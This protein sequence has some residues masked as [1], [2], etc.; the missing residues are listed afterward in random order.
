MT[1]AETAEKTIV[2]TAGTVYSPRSTSRANMTP[3]MGALKVAAIPAAAPEPTSARMRVL[4]NFNLWP[5]T[6]PMAD[7]I[8]TMGPSRPTD[9]PVPMVIADPTA[10]TSMT[11]G[12]MRPPLTAM[13]VM[14]SGTP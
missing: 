1:L 5:T 2:L 14:T 6:E 8:W 12:R 3:A 11:M 7:P 10:F 9:P 4:L 13:A